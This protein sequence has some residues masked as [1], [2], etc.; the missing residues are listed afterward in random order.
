LSA[1]SYWRENFDD[2]LNI[3]YKQFITDR[4]QIESEKSTHTE[5]VID[6]FIKDEVNHFAEVKLDIKKKQKERVT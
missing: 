5:M 1:S 2:Q 6:Q 3:A 4:T